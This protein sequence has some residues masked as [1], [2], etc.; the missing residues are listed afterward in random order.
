MLRENE[1]LKD[2]WKLV[3]VVVSFR[4]NADAATAYEYPIV[5]ENSVFCRLMVLKNSVA[6]V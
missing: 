6:N 2:D 4:F 1:R 5:F 3:V